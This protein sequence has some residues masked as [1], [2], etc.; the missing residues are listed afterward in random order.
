MPAPDLTPQTPGE[1][2]GS[3]T[4]LGNTTAPPADSQQPPA[5]PLYVAKHNGGGRWIV[6]TSDTEANRV[7]DFV[8]DKDSIVAEVERMNAGGEPFAKPDNQPPATSQVPTTTTV[9]ASAIK[10]AVLTDTGWLCPEPPAAK[11]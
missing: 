2:L 9:N 5:P 11:E 1:P 6:V 3:I 10:Q 4:P 8:G 7:G